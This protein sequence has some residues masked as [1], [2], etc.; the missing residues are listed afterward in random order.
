MGSLHVLGI[1]NFLPV[2]GEG[3]RKEGV[4]PIFV[5]AHAMRD[6]EFDMIALKEGKTKRQVDFCS[7][8]GV[9]FI[10]PYR[11]FLLR[12]IVSYMCVVFCTVPN[13]SLFLVFSWICFI[14]RNRKSL[15][16]IDDY[17]EERGKPD[18]ISALT[19]IV[20]AGR[21]A[22]LVSKKYNIPFVARENRTLYSRGG[23]KGHYKNTIHAPAVSA[24]AVIPVSPQ[25][26][27]AMREVFSVDENRVRPIQNAVADEFF[28]KPSG[29][30]EW[31]KVFSDNRFIFA[32]W[33]NWR[34]IK[35]VDIA[36]KAF[37]VLHRDEPGTCLVIA[38]PLPDWTEKMSEEL[39][40]SDSVKFAGSLDRKGV[41]ELAHSCD[42]CIVPSDHDPGN[43]SVLEAM[44]AGKPVI[45]TKCGGS[46]SRITD[47]SL[48]IVVEKGDIEGFA[49]AMKEVYENRISYDAEH[50]SGV[51]R[52]LYSE[53]KL[54]E[55]L[56]AVYREVLEN[57]SS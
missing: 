12:V 2:E 38:G 11:G 14:I 33:T 22:Y 26:G 9:T 13:L 53:K 6:V 10:E 42:C 35:R 56:M 40:I 54:S 3:N 25:L 34:D 7:G 41:H 46:E 31:I 8:L 47:P 29:G 39:G 51:C 5:K 27:S 45:V 1:L 17:I 4:Y 36:L 30:S 48:G 50:I 32:G 18:I 21:A 44:A 16:A 37:A 24:S 19:S 57:K 20:T 49:S 28:I 23:V 43:N 15:A 52:S 55:N